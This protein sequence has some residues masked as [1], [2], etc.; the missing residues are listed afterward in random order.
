MLNP[1]LVCRTVAWVKTM[2]VSEH[3][4]LSGHGQFSVLGL[5]KIAHKSEAL[6][7]PTGQPNGSGSISGLEFANEAKSKPLSEV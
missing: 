2:S 3:L 5:V 7:S 6:C 1:R 4:G